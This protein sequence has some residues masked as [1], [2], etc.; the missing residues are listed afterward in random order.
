MLTIISIFLV[1]N[2]ISGVEIELDSKLSCK[3][4]VIFLCSG[5]PKATLITIPYSNCGF[6]S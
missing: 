1:K 5:L 4:I 2:M 6:N 3:K